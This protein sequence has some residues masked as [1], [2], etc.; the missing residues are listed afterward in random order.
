MTCVSRRRIEYGIA[1][2]I[3]IVVIA[4]CICAWCYCQSLSNDAAI[5]RLNAS[6]AAVAAIGAVFAFLILVV[7]TI[8]T[9]LLRI[10]SDEQLEGGI[11]PVVLL[12]IASGDY[13]VGERTSIKTPQFRNIGMGPAF[14]V[15]VEPIVGGQNC[16]L[17]IDSVPLIESR[18]TVPAVWSAVENNQPSGMAHVDAFLDNL[19][20][21]GKFPDGTRVTVTCKGLSGKRYRLHQVIRH[22]PFTGITW[23][24]FDRIESSGN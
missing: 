17:R 20:A 5:Q 14:S 13:V 6:A 22:D 7:Y 19:F 15:A 16:T 9:R 12:E 18:G 4:L 21:T 2:G 24:E 3:I 11:K 10:A 8:E 23:T 1:I